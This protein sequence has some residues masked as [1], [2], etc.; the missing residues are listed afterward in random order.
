VAY[1]YDD[2]LVDIRHAAE[3]AAIMLYGDPEPGDLYEPEKLTMLEALY[4]HIGPQPKQALRLP[5]SKIKLLPLLLQDAN[6]VFYVGRNYRATLS[7]MN[8]ATNKNIGQLDRPAFFFK[9]NRSVI[10]SG[11]E[12]WACRAEI[13]QLDYEGEIGIVIGKRGKDIP[14]AQ[15]ASYIFGYTVCNDVSARDAMKA[16]YQ[17][18]KGKSFDTFAPVGP[19][20]ATKKEVHEPLAIRTHINGELRQNGDTSDLIFDFAMIIH[21]LS[22]GA[23]LL[24]GDIISTGTLWWSHLSRP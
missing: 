24:P 10:Q 21:M 14:L 15:A 1:F 16:Y 5:I 3:S 20:V 2:Y 17:I 23:T 9:P 11:E 12:I 7:D 8:K 13:S 18:F 6:N 19:C 22:R 4:D